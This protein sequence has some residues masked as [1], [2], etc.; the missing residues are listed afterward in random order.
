MR[1]C[2]RRTNVTS[3]IP[4]Q[5][6]NPRYL[7][8]MAATFASVSQVENKLMKIKFNCDQSNQRSWRARERFHVDVVQIKR[9]N[10]NTQQRLETLYIPRERSLPWR[11]REREREI[12]IGET[13]GAIPRGEIAALAESR[14]FSRLRI[15]LDRRNCILDDF[16]HSRRLSAPCLAGQ[17]HSRRRGRPEDHFLARK[18]AQPEA[19]CGLLPSASRCNKCVVIS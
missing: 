18:S 13:S 16:R 19:K 15:K 10:R 4:R 11:E 3:D 6:F 8:R 14:A 2:S 5:A 1:T 9:M 7:L 12:A 17:R